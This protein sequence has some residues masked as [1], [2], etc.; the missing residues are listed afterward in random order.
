MKNEDTFLMMLLFLCV[1]MTK[2]KLPV[3]DLT[4]A[5]RIALQRQG[6]AGKSF[7]KGKAGALSAIE[8]L[9]YVQLDTLAVVTRAHHHTLWSR[10]DQYREKYLDELLRDRSI[11]EYWSHAASYLPMRDYRFSLVKKQDYL[12]GKSHWFKKDKKMMRY[13]LDRITAEGPLRSTD[14][15]DPQKNRGSWYAWKPAKAALEQLFLDGTLMVRERIGFQ[16]RYDLAERVLP[17]GTDT[18]LPTRD[19]F[20]EHLVLSVLR[21][22]GFAGTRE[23]SYLRR[24]LDQPVKKAIQR[25]AEAGTIIPL[26]IE[27]LDE[28]FYA[29]PDV[30]GKTKP[31]KKNVRLLSP[32]DNALIQRRRI[33]RLFGFDYQIECYLPEP[34]RRFGYFCLPILYGEQFTGRLDPKADRETGIFYV[35]SLHIEHPPKDTDVFFTALADAVRSFANFNG[36]QEIRVERAG[37]VKAADALRKALKRL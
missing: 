4:A 23:I 35:R 12:D 11:F 32:F 2:K 17:P 21:A 19:E 5:R 13:V 36:C 9:G 7:G 18:H 28:V 24:G 27:S 26:E 6:I 14:F 30:F 34:K 10:S 22:H 31:L 29:T 37:T 25:L 16:K 15:E 8:H 20:A 33:I 3:L 1:P